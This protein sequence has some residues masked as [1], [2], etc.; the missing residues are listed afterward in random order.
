[1]HRTD[2]TWN[3]KL[4]EWQQCLCCLCVVVDGLVDEE[5]AGRQ[6]GKLGS[7]SLWLGCH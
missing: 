4:K 3:V 7:L 6:A 2:K 1:M 5:K